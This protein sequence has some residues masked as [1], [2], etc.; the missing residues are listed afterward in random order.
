MQ[1]NLF[2]E[3]KFNI[4]FPVIFFL[5]QKF[6][7]TCPW[8]KV[9]ASAVVLLRCEIKRSAVMCSFKEFLSLECIPHAH[10]HSLS[11]SLS[12]THH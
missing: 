3:D 7:C 10:P 2:C 5:L 11:L 4:F 9:T 12:H 6:L 8:R 1:E